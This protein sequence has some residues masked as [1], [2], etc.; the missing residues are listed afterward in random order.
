MLDNWLIAFLEEAEYLPGVKE[1]EPP[2]LLG[3]CTQ[4]AAA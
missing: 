4:V 2:L 3:Q 1:L